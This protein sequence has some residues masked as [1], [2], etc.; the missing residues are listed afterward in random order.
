MDQ[1]CCGTRIMF[2]LS[3]VN[4]KISNTACIKDPIWRQH[5]IFERNWVRNRKLQDLKLHWIATTFL[6]NPR[7][8]GWNCYRTEGHFWNWPDNFWGK[9]CSLV[10][11]N[12]G[13]I[14]TM[15]I[16]GSNQNSWTQE[17]GENHKKWRMVVCSM[18][19]LWPVGKK[20][21]IGS[22]AWHWQ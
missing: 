4:L 6:T 19:E 22:R 21:R 10:G 12:G 1:Q 17:A 7:R 14:G 15:Y 18:F 2:V 20:L 13:T 5:E 11:R 8:L 3:N 9:Y 16:F